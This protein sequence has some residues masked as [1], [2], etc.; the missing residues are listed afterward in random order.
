MSDLIIKKNK[1]GKPFFRLN[2]RTKR[3][4]YTIFPRFSQFKYCERIALDGFDRL[5]TGF[6]TNDGIGLTGAGYVFLQQTFEKY[7]KKI[8]LTIVAQGKSKFDAR[9]RKVSVR[10][11]HD[12]LTDINADVRSTKRIRNAEV[13]SEVLR[14]LARQYPSQFK[15]FR[16]SAP[17][18]IGGTLA[19]LLKPKAVM[20]KLDA[21]DRVELEGFI[22]D[23]LSTIQGTLRAKKKLQVIF[24]SL[25]AGRKIYLEKIIKEFRSK[26]KRKVQNESV[27]QEFLSNH[28]LLLRNTYGE[29]LEKESV[30][31][32]G[33]FPDFMILDPYSYLDIYEIKKPSTPLLRYDKSRNNYYWDAEIS[34]AVSQ[35]ENYLH[36]VQRHSD[37]LINDVRRNK[38]I[39]IT[40]VRPKGYI[41]AGLRSELTTA[42]MRDDF[43]ILSEAMKNI[44][45]I[46]YD[47]LLSNLESFVKKI[48]T[49]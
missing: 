41:I 32:Q 26:I 13:R 33:K 6:Y 16:K 31:L 44:D 17:Q 27:W 36:Q 4:M 21:D 15:G 1:D 30:S 7:G 34:K 45:I 22:P 10:M 49:Q 24:E 46:L 19:K 35:V 3:G 23:Y 9:G 2:K 28:I 29:V 48:G 37:A 20:G 12:E 11:P 38:G 40:I 5:P 42:K 25:D 47:D 39:D 14:F 8:D 43:R 18:Y